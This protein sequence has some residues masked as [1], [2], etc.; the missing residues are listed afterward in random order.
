MLA[1]TLFFPKDD[2]LGELMSTVCVVRVGGWAGV[3]ACSAEGVG[4]PAGSAGGRLGI[5]YWIS[6]G[7]EKWTRWR[8]KADGMLG[9][10]KPVPFGWFEGVPQSPREPFFLV[11]LRSLRVWHFRIATMTANTS[12]IDQKFIFSC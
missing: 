4:G 2:N 1:L 5:D 10:R 6:Y 11:V 7:K 9:L 3:G 12:G 8:W